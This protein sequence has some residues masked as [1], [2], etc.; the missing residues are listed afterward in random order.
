MEQSSFSFIG[1]HGQWARARVTKVACLG[2]A[3]D[4]LHSNGL[5]KI[6][7]SNGNLSVAQFGPFGMAEEGVQIV[8][9]MCLLRDYYDNA[10]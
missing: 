5:E 8:H 3:A 9:R 7:I 10:V 6:K 1:G 2:E 4:F